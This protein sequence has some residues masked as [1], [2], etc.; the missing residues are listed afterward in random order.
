M[1]CCIIVFALLM[2]FLFALLAYNKNGTVGVPV[3]IGALFIL[4]W[5]VFNSVTLEI[6]QDVCVFK[7]PELWLEATITGFIGA[8]AG[9]K[10]TFDGVINKKGYVRFIVP[11]LIFIGYMIML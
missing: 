3:V 11:V 2:G 9:I 8:F 6:R 4:F 5:A 1:D 7:I 10:N